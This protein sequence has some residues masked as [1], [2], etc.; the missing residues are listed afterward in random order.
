MGAPSTVSTSRLVSGSP[1]GSSSSRATPAS[2]H[3]ERTASGCSSPVRTVTITKAAL[4]STRCR[5]S[6]ADVAVEQLRVVHAEHDRPAAGP[7]A[8]PVRHPAHHVERAAGDP[9]VG[10]QR[11]ERAERDR[12]GAARRLHPCR[13]AA[14]GLGG[15]DGVAGEARLAHARGRADDDA[16]GGPGPPERRDLLE[17]AVAPDQRPFERLRRGGRA[18]RRD[19]GVFRGRPVTHRREPMARTRRDQRDGPRG[20]PVSPA[21]VRMLPSG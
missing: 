10:H 3:S 2:F 20:S 7:L 8:Q 12:G 14:V 5:T 1:S 13:V 6:A 18:G 15:R 4:V 17:L 21:P 9:V 19:A 16:R 11:R